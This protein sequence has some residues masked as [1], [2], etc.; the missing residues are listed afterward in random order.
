MLGVKK[1]PNNVA[2][3]PYGSAASGRLVAGA[4]LGRQNPLE[5]SELNR[6]ENNVKILGASDF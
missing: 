1:S 4:A 6:V 5:D 2:G 3:R